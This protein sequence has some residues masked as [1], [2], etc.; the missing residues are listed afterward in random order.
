MRDPED[1][2]YP[3]WEAIRMEANH[4]VVFEGMPARVK[5]DISFVDTAIRRTGVFSKPLRT[6]ACW[7]EE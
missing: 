4:L 3:M 1:M 5:M 2:H 6:M 7:I